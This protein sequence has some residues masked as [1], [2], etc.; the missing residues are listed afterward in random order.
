MIFLLLDVDSP[1]GGGRKEVSAYG[2]DGEGDTGRIF[3]L[4]L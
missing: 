2:N 1:L 4:K 3:S